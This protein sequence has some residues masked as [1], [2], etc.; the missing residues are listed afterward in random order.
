MLIEKGYTITDDG[1]AFP[2]NFNRL[3]GTVNLTQLQTS[4]DMFDEYDSSSEEESEYDAEVSLGEGAKLG[5]VDHKGGLIIADK[6]EAAT[7]ATAA[8]STTLNLTDIV[9]AD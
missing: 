6:A 2:P 9:A 3:N 5:I 4:T 8:A 1:K 7:A